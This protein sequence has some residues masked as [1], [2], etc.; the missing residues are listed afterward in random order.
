[1]PDLPVIKYVAFGV[2]VANAVD[3]VKA[4]AD[5]ITTRS[6]GHGAGRE[7]IEHILKSSSRWQPL[8][9]RYQ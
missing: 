7:L 9:E 4:H 2:A 5:Y 6:G 1:M 8:M 3:E